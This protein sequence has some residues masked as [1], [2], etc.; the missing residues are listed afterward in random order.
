MFEDILRAVLISGFC[1]CVAIS[2][3]VATMWSTTVSVEGTHSV[4]QDEPK[5]I[6]NSTNDVYLF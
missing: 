3:G 4:C 1:A 6:N 2:T 5:Y